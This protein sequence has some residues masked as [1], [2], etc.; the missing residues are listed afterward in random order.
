MGLFTRMVPPAPLRMMLS[1]SSVFAGLESF[2][3]KAVDSP[4]SSLVEPELTDENDTTMSEFLR[5]S[6]GNVHCIY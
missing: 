6:K 3:P 4:G 1:A 5:V 2:Q